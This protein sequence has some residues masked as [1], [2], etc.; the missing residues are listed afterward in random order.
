MSDSVTNLAGNAE[1]RGAAAAGFQ[2]AKV[3]LS[4]LFAE[5]LDKTAFADRMLSPNEFGLTRAAE[6]DFEA[7]QAVDDATQ[8]RADAGPSEDDATEVSETD[9]QS[10]DG[11]EAQ[12]ED[13]PDEQTQDQDNEMSGSGEAALPDDSLLAFNSTSQDTPNPGLS[14]QPNAASG[15]DL[16]SKV[17]GP[18]PGQAR[19]TATHGAVQAAT[20]KTA[21]ANQTHT[22]ANDAMARGNSA[23]GKA[24][25]GAGVQQPDAAAMKPELGV[26]AAAAK[27]GPGVEAAAVKSGLGIDTAAAKSGLSADA[28]TAEKPQTKGAPALSQSQA[29]KGADADGLGTSLEK[30]SLLMRAGA[31]RAAEMHNMKIRLS[32]HHDAIKKAITKSTASSNGAPPRNTASSADKPSIEVTTSATPPASAALVG[33]PARPAT[34]FNS[35]APGSLPGQAGVN[36]SANMAIGEIVG[37]GAEQSTAATDRQAM[38]TSSPR[39]LNLRPAVGQPAYQPAEQVKVHIQQ[40]MKSDADRIQIKL[41][42]ATL[43]RVEV[44][45]EMTPDKVVQAVV[46]AEKPETLDMLERDA[47]VLQKAFEEAGMKFDSNSLTFQHGQPGNSDAEFAE[48]DARAE[49]GAAADGD[50]SDATETTDNDKPRRRQHDGMLDLEI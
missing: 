17:E 41:S 48:G 9:G 1:P 16:Q 45:L 15:V 49:N 23:F 31:E 44:T 3:P 8:D 11:D 46:Y 38:T 20:P 37:N 35:M 19:A 12:A 34:L 6:R 25:S 2:N 10:G 26:D 42:P 22:P 47:R 28:A 24:Q 21:N 27:S 39:G 32:A 43:G 50:G 14:V 33:P 30:H 40:L 7:R 5:V 4:D 29:P 13:Q 18:T 36:G